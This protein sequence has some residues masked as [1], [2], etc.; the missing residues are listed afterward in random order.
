LA[1][2]NCKSPNATLL[3]PVAR[4]SLPVFPGRG[5]RGKDMKSIALLQ[6]NFSLAPNLL[7]FNN[8]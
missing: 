6:E 8:L 1:H 4:G 5:I 2:L 3:L 7:I